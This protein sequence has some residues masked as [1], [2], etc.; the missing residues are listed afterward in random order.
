MC[1]RSSALALLQSRG[2]STLIIPLCVLYSFATLTPSLISR[3]PRVYV[4]KLAL[5]IFRTNKSSVFS[6]STQSTWKS[7]VLH[8]PF[9]GIYIEG[10]A[11]SG[12]SKSIIEPIIS[13]AVAQGYAG[14]LYDFKGNPPTL[15]S[16][17]NGAVAK[18]KVRTQFAH[19]NLSSPVISHRCNPL[20]PNYFPH[21]YYAHEYASVILKN[22]NKEWAR[23]ID[24]WAENAI[25]YLAAIL[26]YL[27][28]HHPQLC[29]LPHATLLAMETPEK[30]LSLL[31]RDGETKRMVSAIST[32]YEN[33]AEKQIAG[34]FSSLQLS[35][36]KL[37]T[38]EIFWILSANPG[39]VGHVSL[40]V[41]H[42]SQPQLLS[43]A[44]DPVLSDVFSPII[45]LI[46]MVCIKNMNQQGKHQSVFILDEA[47]T[48]FIPGLA[49]L[50]ATA[51]SNKV[52]S[53]VAVQDFTQLQNIYGNKAAET[54][55]NNLGNQFFG[56]TNNLGTA[57]YVSKMAGFYNQMK[58]SVSDS[59]GPHGSSSSQTASLH[60]EQYVD[61]HQVASQPSGHFI[62]K[63]TGK[64]PRFFANQ[65]KAHRFNMKAPDKI[66]PSNRLDTLVEEKWQA[67]HREVNRII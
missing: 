10:S 28:K 26:W 18:S 20:S 52:V 8:N 11:G 67:I 29:S 38:R 37:Y 31:N 30:S 24:F 9:Q 23:K 55:R 42:P 33:N 3:V 7:I 66:V 15:S 35:L 61:A 64:T 13:Q 44:N 1:S 46:A 21:K 12:K 65:L 2:E 39:D 56:M 14:F 48:L 53:V 62:T 54:I 27:R 40:D 60:K 45:A 43:V 17:M 6:F 41:S 34:I 16:C 32:A 51:R 49:N 58:T 36:S 47:P 22:L 63:V 59:S 5:G 25:A 50:P 4:K 57:E 19:I